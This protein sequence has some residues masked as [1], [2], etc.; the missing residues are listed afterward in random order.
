MAEEGSEEAV[1]GVAGEDDGVERGGGE[2]YVDAL[3]VGEG[4]EGWGKRC[5]GARGMGAV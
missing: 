4:V 5:E 2:D 1:E 3:S